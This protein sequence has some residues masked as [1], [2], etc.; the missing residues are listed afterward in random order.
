MRRVLHSLR[1][2]RHF[3]PL[4][5]AAALSACA[6]AP[7]DFSDKLRT[8]GAQLNEQADRWSKGEAMAKEGNALI[9]EGRDL[10]AEGHKKIDAGQKMAKEGHRMRQEVETA[11]AGQAGQKQD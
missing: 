8:Q 2:R 5:L 1:S 9:A 3:A 10:V 6:S 4:V 11:Y 7:E